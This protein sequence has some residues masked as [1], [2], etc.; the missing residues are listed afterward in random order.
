MTET[1]VVNIEASREKFAAKVVAPVWHTIVVLA[2]LAGMASLALL[3]GGPGHIAK[4]HSHVLGYGITM[5]IEWLIVG[6]IALGARWGGASLR[7]LTGRVLPGWRAMLRDLGIAIAYLVVAQVVLGAASFALSHIL[8]PTPADVIRNMLPR[9]WLENGAFLLLTLT[10]GI[11][12]EMIFRGYLQHQLTA[13]FGGAAS[14]VLQGALFGAAHAYQGTAMVI[15]IAIFG[16]MFGLLALWRKNLRP[17][18][19]AHFIQDAV[20]GLVL[21]KFVLK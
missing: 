7:V 15:V 2:L 5:A 12:E 18:M 6:F 8:P 9:T 17:G 14:I 13:W 16:C 11:C 20:G 10:A 3:S 1:A 19:L 21:A 4:G